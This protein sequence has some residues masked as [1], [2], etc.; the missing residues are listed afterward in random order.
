MGIG[1]FG[2]CGFKGSRVLG[3]PDLA[4]Q[5]QCKQGWVGGWVCCCCVWSLPT[6][7][8]LCPNPVAL[9]LLLTLLRHTGTQA[10]LSGS[11]SDAV[12]E[13]GWLTLDILQVRQAAR[14][15]ACRVQDLDHRGF[16]GCQGL[17]LTAG[18]CSLGT[19]LVS[20]FGG[21]GG[22]RCATTTA[23]TERAVCWCC[24][25]AARGPGAAGRPGP[26]APRAAHD[27][28]E[29]RAELHPPLLLIYTESPPPALNPDPL[30][31]LHP[32]PPPPR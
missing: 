2:V 18:R 27:G 29:G 9:G 7:V 10:E 4:G 3:R 14:A 26:P 17:A 28:K 23:T 8:R 11:V 15:R 5:V 19:W 1:V 20:W 12:E 30:S 13:D 22:R 24:V 32:A 16:R 31:G 25:P 6:R 21:P